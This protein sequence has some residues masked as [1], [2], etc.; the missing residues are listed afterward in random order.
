MAPNSQ[1]FSIILG[2]T[3]AWKKAGESI[4]ISDNTEKLLEIA[5]KEANSVVSF[6]GS[7]NLVNNADKTALLYNSKEKV[8]KFQ[9]KS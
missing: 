5:T 1:V 8:E 9:L 2:H 3:T 6:F 4:I 7:N